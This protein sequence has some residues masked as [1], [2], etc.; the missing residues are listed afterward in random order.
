RAFDTA[1]M[2]DLHRRVVA[3]FEAGAQ[4]AG[5][6]IAVTSAEPPYA[7][8]RQDP[9]LADFYARN[10]ALVG[11]APA[12]RGSRTVG[13]TDMGNVTQALPG[14]HPMIAIAG[15]R[16]HPHTTGFAEDARSPAADGTVVDGALA[17]AFTGVDVAAD[18]DARSRFRAAHRAR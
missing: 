14:L 18:P 12:P 5:A 2:D 4:A 3:C 13:S 8:V 16:N 17:L 11:R 6:E 10:L 7:P 15:A 1:T 9:V